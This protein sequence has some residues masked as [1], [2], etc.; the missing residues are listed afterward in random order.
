MNQVPKMISTKDLSYISDMFEWNFTVSK[1]CNS[2][3]EKI[4]AEDI[5]TIISD[6]G[7]MHANICAKLVDILGGS[8]EQQ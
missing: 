3:K 2:Y 6:I 4:E 5:K 1:V 8:Y 7:R